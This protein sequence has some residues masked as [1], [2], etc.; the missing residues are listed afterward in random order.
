MVVCS[1]LTAQPDMAESGGNVFVD[2]DFRKTSQF[3]C[4]NIWWKWRD[5]AC[6]N[7]WNADNDNNPATNGG[8]PDGSALILTVRQNQS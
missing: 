7:D 6:F 4:F 1:L 5:F 8:Q 2:E 3:S